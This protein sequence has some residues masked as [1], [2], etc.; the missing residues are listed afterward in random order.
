MKYNI[1]PWEEDNDLFLLRMMGRWMNWYSFL[2][3]EVGNIPITYMTQVI[4][5]SLRRSHTA[6]NITKANS[7]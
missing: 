5:Y 4:K 2:M 3:F 1:N 7:D 6:V